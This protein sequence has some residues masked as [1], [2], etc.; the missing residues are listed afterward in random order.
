MLSPALADE[1]PIEPPTQDLGYDELKEKMKKGDGSKQTAQE[2]VNAT[3][4][5]MRDLYHGW[6]TEEGIWAKEGQDK[7][8]RALRGTGDPEE[9][10]FTL[11]IGG[12]IPR[13]VV[14]DL[15]RSKGDQQNREAQLMAVEE[16]AKS[17]E[18]DAIASR[19]RKLLIR[20]RS[21]RKRGA[22]YK[23]KEAVAN[24][25]GES[26]N[27]V[28]SDPEESETFPSRMQRKGVTGMAETRSGSRRWY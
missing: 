6:T 21:L 28:G 9:D 5:Q 19:A 24:I 23:L 12:L 15:V 13:D 18:E 22:A 27:L 10:L 26:P 20:S 1:K 14:K 2:M 4:R 7:L 8:K 17:L 11:F 3:Q 25:Q 16:L